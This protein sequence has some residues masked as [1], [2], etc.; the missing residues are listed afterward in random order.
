MKRKTRKIPSRNPF[1]HKPWHPQY[2]VW[3][4]KMKTMRKPDKSDLLK[5]KDQVRAL[6]KMFPKNHFTKRKH[7]SRPFT[8][9][10]TDE[11]GWLISVDNH[12]IWSD[13][14]KF[15]L[16]KPALEK[17]GYIFVFATNSKVMFHTRLKVY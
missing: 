2:R 6:N 4:D 11:G 7:Q 8:G 12:Y 15:K 16:I 17:K 10:F 14:P 5:Y 3:R 13:D 1:A 9:I